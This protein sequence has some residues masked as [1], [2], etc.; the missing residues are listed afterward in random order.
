MD[1]SKKENKFI[2]IV[3]YG[4]ICAI[5]ILSFL[6][7]KIYISQQNTNLENDITQIEEDYKRH[8]KTMIKGLVNKVHNLI[9]LE[10]KYERIDFRNELKEEIHQA[11][12][13]VSQIYNNNINKPDYSE[14]KTLDL[15]KDALRNFKFHSPNGYFFI[16]EMTGKVILN[17]QLP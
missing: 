13:I 10:Q 17:K 3:K 12:S 6:I 8:N 15:I 5:F 2:N 4:A 14:E 1:I 7:T 16:F 11:Y 9:D